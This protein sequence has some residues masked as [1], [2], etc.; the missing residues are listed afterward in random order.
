MCPLCNISTLNCCSLCALV[1]T[2]ACNH[3]ESALR[4]RGKRDSQ[5]TADGC[6]SPSPAIPFGVDVSVSVTAKISLAERTGALGVQAKHPSRQMLSGSSL[7]KLF[8]KF[9]E[10]M[11]SDGE[12][13]C[14]PLFASV[15]NKSS[16]L[17]ALRKFCGLVSTAGD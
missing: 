8:A 11:S 9:I 13:G 6:G 2:N 3:A 14:C 16:R 7:S 4:E 1:A 10:I 17:N 15:G 12:A 5:T